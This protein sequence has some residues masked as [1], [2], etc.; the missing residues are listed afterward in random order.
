MPTFPTQRL[1]FFETYESASL[2]EAAATNADA[3]I[4]LNWDVVFAQKV[5]RNFSKSSILHHF[6]YAIIS[7]DRRDDY[8]ENTEEY[9]GEVPRYKKIFKEYGIK[10]AS[11]SSNPKKKPKSHPEEYEYFGEWFVFH[12]KSFEELWKLIADEVFYILFSNRSFLLRF[13][14]TLAE[15]IESRKIELPSTY[16]TS[17]GRILRANG[18]PAWVKKAVF[19]R[20]HASNVRFQQ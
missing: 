3:F 12:E 2:I 20:D 5:L 14:L 18:V 4:E 8:R 19:L 17:S 11:L 9:W 10:L 15:F 1:L 7:V 13:N 16:L 6:I